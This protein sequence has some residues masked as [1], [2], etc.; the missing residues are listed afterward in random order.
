MDKCEEN[1]VYLTFVSPSY[2]SQMTDRKDYL[3]N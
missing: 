3:G 1:R 2:N